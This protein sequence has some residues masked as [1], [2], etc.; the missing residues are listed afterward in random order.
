[1]LDLF[2]SLV[3]G[4]PWCGVQQVFSYVYSWQCLGWHHVDLVFVRYRVHVEVMS[5]YCIRFGCSA[6]QIGTGYLGCISRCRRFDVSV[7]FCPNDDFPSRSSH[8]CKKL[9]TLRKEWFYYRGDV[10]V[11]KMPS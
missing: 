11:G 7:E 9:Q 10:S 8:R 3:V 4:L 2:G 6:N 5:W 1:M